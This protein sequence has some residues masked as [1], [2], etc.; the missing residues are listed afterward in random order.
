MVAPSGSLVLGLA[1]LNNPAVALNLSK[2]AERSE[3]QLS[4]ARGGPAQPSVLASS[5]AALARSWDRLTQRELSVQLLWQ[6]ISCKAPARLARPVLAVLL[7]TAGILAVS[8]V[9]GPPLFRLVVA[10]WKTILLA[11]GVFLIGAGVILAAGRV[12]R[13]P[14]RNIQPPDDTTNEPLEELERFATRSAS[15]LRTAYQVQLGLICLVAVAIFAIVGWSVLMVTRH[16]LMYATVF[17]TTGVGMLALSKWK[18]QPF[19]RVADA[20]RLAD[21]ADILATGLRLRIESIS[22]IQDPKERAQAQWQ[23]VN[24]YLELS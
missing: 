8:V 14:L 6:T 15:R 12:G 23:A 9:L 4:P 1:A 24:D 5:P 20:R 19:D 21:N 10:H 13:T 11:L 2:L 16:Q 7:L 18:W 17:G 22:E 3:Q